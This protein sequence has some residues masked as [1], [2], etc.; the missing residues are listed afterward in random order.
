MFIRGRIFFGC[1][2]YYTLSR[3]CRLGRKFQAFVLQEKAESNS[4]AGE[5]LGRGLASA[6]VFSGVNALF[7]SG[8]LQGQL[9]CPNPAANL[10]GEKREEKVSCWVS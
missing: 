2:E 6:G 4:G 9:L 10:V 7:H 1:I 8:N 3:E 5:P